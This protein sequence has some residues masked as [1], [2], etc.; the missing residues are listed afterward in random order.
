LS[1]SLDGAGVPVVDLGHAAT[2]PAS[3]YDTYA[4]DVSKLAG[5]PVTLAF[6]SLPS[7]HSGSF[8]DNISFSPVPIAPEPS[9]Y[10]LFGVGAAALLWFHRRK[11]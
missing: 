11:P 2:G 1:V 6:S 3:L 7:P 9:T 8:L 4:V 10:A 5:Q